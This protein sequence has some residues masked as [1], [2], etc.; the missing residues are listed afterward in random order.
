MSL[1]R[2]GWSIVAAALLLAPSALCAQDDAASVAAEPSGNWPVIASDP[3][4]E[5]LVELSST[6]RQ[7]GSL[8]RRMAGAAM[9]DGD[10]GLAREAVMRFATLGGSL[11]PAGRE[12]VSPMFAPESWARVAARMDENAGP[13]VNSEAWGEVPAELG[14]IE[15]IVHVP[16]DGDF[17]VSSVTGRAIYQRNDGGWAPFG[18]GNFQIWPDG[19]RPGSLLGMAFDRDRGWLWAAASVLDQTP[20]P[21]TAISALIGIGPGQNEILRLPVEG[22]QPGDVALGPD[23]SVYVSDSATGAIYVR[24]I[25]SVELERLLEP[26]RLRSPQ[27]MA[28]SPDGSALIIADY[29]YGLARLDFASGSLDA[30]DYS[31]TEMLDGID[32]LLRHGDALIAIR[33]GSRPSAILQISIDPAGATVRSVDILERAQADRGEPTLGTIDGDMLYYI[34]DARWPD[35]GEGGGLNADAAARPT[36]IRTLHLPSRQN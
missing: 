23:G 35:F 11:S 17:L 27:G 13:I 4:T 6:F 2:R 36:T 1:T 3:D 32:G 28:V 30:V 16:Y 22:G 25:G 34:A 31:G 12:A 24:R 10:L 33:N 21:E 14:L 15:G 29:H 7:S 20:D 9:A 26:G 5:G 19:M 18:A 8:L